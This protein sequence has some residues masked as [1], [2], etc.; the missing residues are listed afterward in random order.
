MKP[1][2]ARHLSVP[3][4]TQA[5]AL[6]LALALSATLHPSAQAAPPDLD[7]PLVF[8]ALRVG[9]TEAEVLRTLGVSPREA[10]RTEFAGLQKLHL[11]FE[12]GQ[13]R[14]EVT[15]IGGRLMSKSATTKPSTWRLPW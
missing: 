13:H 8:K 15:L 6:C 14:I 2:T 12:V 5:L 10:Q 3:W 11:V 9:D 1:F 7:A 4:M